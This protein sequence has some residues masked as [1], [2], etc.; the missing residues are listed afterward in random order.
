MESDHQLHRFKSGSTYE[1]ALKLYYFDKDLRAILFTAIQSIE[2]ALRASIIQNVSLKY[3][4][5]WF[6]NPD[7]AVNVYYAEENLKRIKLEITRSKEDFIQE[8]FEKYDSPEFPPVWKTLET[9]SFGLLSKLVDNLNDV[10][11]QKDIARDFSLPQHI[12]LKSWMASCSVLRNLIAHHSRIWNRRFAVKPKIPKKLEGAWITS[13]NE[14][15]VK[16]YPQ[17]CCLAYLQNAIHPNNVFIKRLKELFRT[18]PNVD[19]KAMGFPDNWQSQP[20]W[21]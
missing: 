18:N 10:Q 2:I 4:A 17:L 12:Y 21:E 3:G 20:I 19:L 7:L 11:I 8:Y 1:N 14:A 15:P 13:Y 16:L 5:F 6:M 9:I